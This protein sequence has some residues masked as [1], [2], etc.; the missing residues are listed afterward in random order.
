[1]T[2]FV[3]ALALCSAVTAQVSAQF[4]AG[5]P[6]D[7]D[8]YHNELYLEGAGSYQRILYEDA[9]NSSML[10][11]MIWSEIHVAPCGEFCLLPVFWLLS[12][13]TR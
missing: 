9:V 2:N 6:V 7:V 1:M 11:N 12:C 13:A 4:L 5:E 8:E 3:L 10:T